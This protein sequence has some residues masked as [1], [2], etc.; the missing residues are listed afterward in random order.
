MVDQPSL[1][2]D[3]V[4]LGIACAAGVVMAP[5]LPLV[6]LPTAAAAAAGLTFRGS[7]GAA[8]LGFA[9]GIA[10]AALVAPGSAL[11]AASVALAVTVAIAL[12]PSKPV[13]LVG[14]IA[15]VIVTAGAM[16]ADALV[17]R[18]AGLTLVGAV[19]EQSAAATQA[20]K[21]VLGSSGGW[22]EQLNTARAALVMLWPSFYV[23]TAIFGAIFMIAAIAW[24]ARRSDTPLDVPT[25]RNL[26][27]TG[28]VLWV[29]VGGL[30][31]LA[32]APVF[33][34]Q[35]NVARAVAINLL[36]VTRTLFFVQ[37][38][39]VFSAVFDVPKT[40]QPKMVALYATLWLLDQFLLF[41]SLIGMLDF[42]A[43]FRRL[44]RDGSG[45]PARLEEPPASV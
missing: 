24:A 29:F 38:V 15:A 35:A 19:R 21:Q 14:A 8:L 23:Q 37:G 31:L 34:A 7:R 5:Q 16:G 13:Q 26:D 44:P 43:N 4:L 25:N 17:A 11:F 28:H 2:R 10:L 41:V 18:S 1:M 36:F 22:A 30:I 40:G 45:A 42:W 39:A 3:T 12:L 20:L 33:G 9:A 6:G 27:I 32:A